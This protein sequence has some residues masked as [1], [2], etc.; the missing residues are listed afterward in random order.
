[1]IPLLFY[2]VL[3]CYFIRLSRPLQPIVA[4]KHT[5]PYC[6][7]IEAVDGYSKGKKEASAII[8]SKGTSLIKFLIKNL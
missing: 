7:P 3:L 4:L 6:E 1:M 5:P 2:A 8:R